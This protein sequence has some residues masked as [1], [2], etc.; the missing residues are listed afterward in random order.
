MAEPE[1]NVVEPATTLGAQ[2]PEG[3]SA[4]Q[5]AEHL[6]P[7]SGRTSVLTPLNHKVYSDQ[8]NTSTVLSKYDLPR[9]TRGNVSIR[10]TA[11]NR[12]W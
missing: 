9:D 7:G 11:K 1:V 6:A 5:G 8:F 12:R 3:T 4:I 2:P 10:C